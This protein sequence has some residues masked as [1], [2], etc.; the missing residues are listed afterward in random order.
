MSVDPD[1][2]DRDKPSRSSLIGVHTVCTALSDSKTGKLQYVFY[3][4]P[5]A[6]LQ[7]KYFA[8]TEYS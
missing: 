8:I 7:P 6:K 2:T 5:C 1:L 3:Q 4:A